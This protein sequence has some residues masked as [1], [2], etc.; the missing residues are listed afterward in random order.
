M[1][2]PEQYRILILLVSF[3][4]IV[5][6]FVFI[7]NRVEVKLLLQRIDTACYC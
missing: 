6:V 1:G 4:F 7:Y 3:L 2:V 5:C